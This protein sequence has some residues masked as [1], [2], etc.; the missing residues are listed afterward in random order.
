MKYLLIALSIFLLVMAACTPVPE[1]TPEAQTMT[2]TVYF[3][4]QSRFAIGTEPY[5]DSVTRTVPA[6]D[7]IPAAVLEQLFIGPTAAE[8]DQGLALILSGATGFSEFYVQDGVAHVFLTGVCSSGGSTYTIG[9]LIYANLEQFP[10]ITAVKIYDQNGE[11]EVPDGA[12]SSI[13]FCLEP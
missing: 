6:S 4:N 13:P 8:K 2:I 3:Q 12:S 7:D 11:T 10:E 5:E 1:N 9:N